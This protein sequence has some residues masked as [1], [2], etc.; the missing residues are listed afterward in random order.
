MIFDM[1]FGT[2]LLVFLFAIFLVFD[3]EILRG[4]FAKKIR[5]WFGVE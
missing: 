5:K 2:I 1:F 3:N 4:H